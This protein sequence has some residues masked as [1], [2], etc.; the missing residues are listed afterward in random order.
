MI[1]IC[2]TRFPVFT[3]ELWG[4]TFLFLILDA[5]ILKFTYAKLKKTYIKLRK[6]GRQRV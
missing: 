6:G 1:K 5:K 2:Y 4:H 3:T